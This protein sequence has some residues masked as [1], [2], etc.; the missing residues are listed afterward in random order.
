[1]SM[2]NRE[3]GKHGYG[4]THGLVCVVDDDVSV[5]R[6]LRNLLG[7]EGHRVETFASAEAFLESEARNTAHCLVL[8]LRMPGMGGSELFARLTAAE[9][10]I[11][12]VI[13]TADA[14]D[15]LKQRYLRRGAIAFLTKPYR[16]GD[17]LRAVARGLAVRPR[18]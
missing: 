7:S 15:E 8:D 5:L 16:P 12:T 17:M 3:A 11:P 1:M 6:S 2:S 10:P 18:T 4:D 14:D 9:R 13:L